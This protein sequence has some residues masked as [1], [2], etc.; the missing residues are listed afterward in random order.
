MKWL[1]L[2]GALVILQ[3]GFWLFSPAKQPKALPDSKIA[4]GPNEAALVEGRPMQR[5]SALNALDKPT[6]SRCTPDGRKSFLSGLSYYYEM[7]QN[8]MERYPETYGKLGADYIAK[9]WASPDDRRIDRLTQ[10]AYNKGYLKPDDFKGLPRKIVA[11][12]VKS[13]KVVSKG[14]S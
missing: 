9:Q 10:E 11:D 1:Y 3:V 4:Y 13:E 14:C 6:A 8:Q 2:I 7:R 5:Q 12:V